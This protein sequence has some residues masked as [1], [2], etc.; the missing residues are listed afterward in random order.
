[1]SVF[2][3]IRSN[4]FGN[5]EGDHR[6]PLCDL[7]LIKYLMMKN[8][9]SR[10]LLRNELATPNQV[11]KVMT[12]VISENID[13]LLELVLYQDKRGLGALMF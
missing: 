8:W 9:L 6:D 11:Q 4:V 13:T 10:M 5:Q 3:V 12:L 2:R 1:M 7:K